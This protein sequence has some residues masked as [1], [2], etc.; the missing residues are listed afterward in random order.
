MFSLFRSKASHEDG[1]ALRLLG[2]VSRA[3]RSPDLFGP[4]RIADTFD[5]RFEAMALFSWLAVERLKGQA[6]GEKLAQT[7]TDAVF[8]SFDAG[9]REAAIGDLSVAKKI[10]KLAASYYGRLAAYGACDGPEALA[11]AL[12]RNIWNGQGAAFAPELSQRIW[13]LKQRLAATPLNALDDS[14]VWE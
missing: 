13:A 3:A 7:F 11:A 12:A 6:G 1:A 9:L 14:G 4:G 5:G 8:A 2:A 10:K